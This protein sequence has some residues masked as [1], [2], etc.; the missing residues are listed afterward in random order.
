MVTVKKKKAER[1]DKMKN[2]EKILKEVMKD[3]T[4]PQREIAKKLGV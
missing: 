3:P 1:S 4:Q 2:R